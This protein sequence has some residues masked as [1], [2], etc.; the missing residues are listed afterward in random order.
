MAT[1]KIKIGE[2]RDIPEHIFWCKMCGK[3]LY[4]AIVPIHKLS[5]KHYEYLRYDLSDKGLMFLQNQNNKN[6][7]RLLVQMHKSE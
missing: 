7:R 1:E 3:L 4:E 6:I 2:A 5:K